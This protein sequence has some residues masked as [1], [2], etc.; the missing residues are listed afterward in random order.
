MDEVLIVLTTFPDLET[1][2]QIGTNLVEEQV[3][4]CV[5]LL[6]RA[7]SI[8][9]WQG[10]VET[11]AEIPAFIKTTRAGFPKLEETLRRLHPYE[12]PEIIALPVQTGAQTYLRWVAENV[13]S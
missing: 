5:N 8:Y 3:A 1:A 10:A 9:R 12:V 2:R 4:A 6:P 7:E 13:A 11:A